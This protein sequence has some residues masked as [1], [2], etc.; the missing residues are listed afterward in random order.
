MIENNIEEY[1]K[2]LLEKK[3]LLDSAIVQL[4]S[5]FVGIDNVI[6]QIADAIGA[7]LFFPEMQEKPVIINLWG[8][9]G[10]GKT[11]LVKRFSQLID[12]NER[13][14]R[15]DLGES[16]GKYFDIQDSFKEIYENCDK[17]P[18]IIGLDEFQFAR[19][20]NENQEEIDK[21]SSR[22]IWDLLDSG[23]FDLIDFNYNIGVFSKLIKKLDLSLSKGVEVENGLVTL[24]ADI[25]KNI[26]E[27]TEEDDN[28]DED[29]NDESSKINKEKKLY[30][31]P[32]VNL[33]NIF[34]AVADMFL[35]KSELRDKLD[36][37][38]G[39]ATIEYLIQLYKKTLK[40]KTVDC[41]KALVFIMGNLDE[42]YSMT[43]DFNPDMNADEFNKQSLKI[44]VTQVKNALLARFRSEQIARLG[45]IHIIYPS[46]TSEAF[47]R[48][49]ELELSKIQK[50]IK[51][52]YNFDLTFDKGINELIYEEGVYPTQGT[53]P[54]FTTVQQIV[55][56]RLGKILNEV[57]INGYFVDRLHFAIDE[58][59]STKDV[60]S[61]KIKFYKDEKLVHEWADKQSL[62]LGKLRQ[63]KLN[64]EQAIVA[65]H[66][67]G[68]AI[69]S[70][71]LMHTIPDSIF[72][73]TADSNSQGFVLARPQW[74]Y[75]SK[76]EI[77]NRLAVLM[78]G[79]VAERIVF[80]DENITIGA[81]SDLQNATKLATY[82]LYACGMGNM[83]ALFG[84]ENMDETPN[85]IFDDA[86]EGINREA[87]ALLEAAE[88]LAQKTLE[89][90]RVLLL[91]LAN[92]L[93]D[94]RA[95]SKDLMMEFL[96]KYAVDF[97]KEDIITDADHLFYRDHLKKQVDAL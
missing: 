69:V 95:V 3:N 42:V 8:L 14:Y 82:V 49:I 39:E 70:S 30:F 6:D 57:Y 9:T 76:K 52:I 26:L 92:Y 20:I 12:Y 41:S 68:H 97:K 86:R 89:T 78:G 80:G 5:E 19:T 46:F 56:A 59:G 91:Q 66:E 96:V 84:N 15:F 51:S 21:S 34:Y 87:K 7:W 88:N 65:V 22:A 67:S 73:V 53:R 94:K 13:Y 61:L 23:K 40:P 18:F 50:K 58:E 64:D 63:E 28:D 44:S 74:N 45:N 27:I 72:S 79:L 4:K 93:S 33:N 75:I 1:R 16:T 10:I 29:S 25:H 85:V 11:S 35:S 83:L 48:I 2:D 62:V 36:E 31:I 37:L 90:Q 38:D 55:N 24:N 54:L 71:I 77:V 81:S 17:E 43:H 32:E 47:H 60:A